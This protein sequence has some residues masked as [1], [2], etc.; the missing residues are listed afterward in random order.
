[1]ARAPHNITVVACLAS[2]WRNTDISYLYQ[3]LFCCCLRPAA[4]WAENYFAAVK[5]GV[6]S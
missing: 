1:M 6:V 3:A 4:A 2:S 5:R